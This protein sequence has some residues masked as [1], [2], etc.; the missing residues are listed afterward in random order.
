MNNKPIYYITRVLLT[1]VALLAAPFAGA[2]TTNWVAY[3]DHRPTTTPVVNGWRITAT[4]VSGYDMG[5]PA[6]LAASPLTNFLTGSPLAA[7]VSFTRTGGPDDFGGVG[8]P[9]PTNTPMARLFY[10]VCDLA[11]DGIVGVRSL[12]ATPPNAAEAYVTITFNG[13]NP[14]KRYVFRGSAARNGSYAPRWS[15]AAIQANDSVDAHINGNGGPGVLTGANFPSSAL[16]PG[17]A[18]WNSGHNAEGA[19]IGWDFISPFPDG[20]FSITCKQYTGATPAGTANG[21]YGYSF[22]AL[23]LA[24]VEAVAPTIT[25]NPAATTTVEQNRPFSLSVAA[26]G[27]PL[28]Y[29]WY[30]QGVGAITGATFPTYSVPQAA[31]TNSGMYYA[32]VYNPLSRATSAVAQVNVFADTTG[33][34]VDAVFTYPTVAAGV[35]TLNQIII[36]FNEPVTSASVSSPASYTVSGGVGN[37]AAVIVT[38][39]AVLSISNQSVTN[40]QS[41]VLVL[42]SPLTQDTDYSVTLSGA[43]DSLGNVAGSSSAP[44][45][46]WVSGAGNGLLFEA[47]NV[48]G[49]SVEVFSLTDSPNY[50]DNPFTRTN[51]GVLDSRAA[52]PDNTNNAYGGRIRGVFIPPVS[53][54]WSFFFR[55]RQRGVVYLNPNGTDPAGKIEILRESTGNTPLNW[56]RFT[57]PPQSLRA[58]RAY[59]IESLYKEG[60]G[61]ADFI[62]VAARLQGTGFPTPVD[63]PDI[64]LDSNSLAGAAVAFPL[65]PRA[66]GG[67][68]TFV[69][70]LQNLKVEQNH[71]AVFAPQVSNPSGLPLSYRWF[72]SGTAIPGANGPSYSFQVANGDNGATFRVEAAKLGAFT[73]SRTATLTVVP[74]TNGPAVSAA[75]SSATNLSTLVVRFNEIMDVSLAQEP[76]NYQIDGNSVSQATLEPDGRTVTLLLSIPLTLNTSYQLQLFD[77]RDLAGNAI[78]PNPATFTFT[79]GVEPSANPALRLSKNGGALVMSWDAPARLQFTTSLTPPVVWQDVNT[80][81]AITFTVNPSN[82]FN[83]S[84]DALQ[85]PAPRGTGSGR[86]TVTLSNN[87]LVVD[88]AYS[89]LSGTRNNSHFHAPAPR[90]VSAGVVYSTATIDSATG[91]NTNAGTIKGTIPLVDNTYGSKNIAAQIQD[92][93]NG[94]WYLNVHSTTFG[95][96]EIRGQVEAGARFYRLIS[97]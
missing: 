38:N 61:G 40:Y 19:V 25:T 37:P 30:K 72:R 85:E 67:T 57:S 16:P 2:Q 27:T 62:K 71:F 7:T 83:V 55:T 70:D 6:D 95:G 51:L 91:L 82:E 10:G 74:D 44:F 11:N 22:G 45:H 20:S 92:I 1:T 32:V 26:T 60:D 47:F 76:G 18:A 88:V 96:G 4:N 31:L 23:L 36:E 17:Q 43:V 48:A 69:Q 66:L 49:T 77:M 28:L 79:A 29:Q 64:Q 52:F 24:E 50:P 15:V 73:N 87:I 58:G 9:I 8:R 13:L 35:A 14:A 33:P 94:L 68:L 34:T 53:G 78:N 86:G 63:T 65:A 3:N 84:L 97:P 75:T 46:S 39:M 90:G 42:A 41:V 59:Y 93:R 12:T 5:A 54:N 21:P 89:G 80:G 56:D 81:G